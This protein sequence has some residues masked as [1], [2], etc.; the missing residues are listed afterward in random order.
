VNFGLIYG[1]G[2]FRLARDSDLTLG[3]AEK[4]I[5]TYFERLPKVQE[6]IEDTKRKAV[7]GLSTLFGRKRYFA[8][9]SDP[10]SSRNAREAELRAAV[11]M[12]IQGTAADIIK[13][14]MIDL[15]AEL[16]RSQLDALMTLQVHDEL[17]LDVA[18]DQIEET[19]ALVVDVMENAYTLKVPLKANAEIGQ[20]WRDMSPA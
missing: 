20:N 11:N 6:Y 8:A 14:A 17:L 18:V 9:L 7:D 13:K 3:E 12:P 4:F 1:M 5:N 2:P 15:Y 10:R 19:T 16:Q